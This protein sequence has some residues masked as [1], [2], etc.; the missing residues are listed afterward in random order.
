LENQQG[1]LPKNF[2]FSG[3]EEGLAKEVFE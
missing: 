1:I 3:E 2:Q